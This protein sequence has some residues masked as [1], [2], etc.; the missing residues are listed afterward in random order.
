[1]FTTYFLIAL[2]ASIGWLIKDKIHQGNDFDIRGTWK[3]YVGCLIGGLLYG[4]LSGWH[5]F[6][7]VAL[8]GV[9][10]LIGNS[11]S[12]VL[13]FLNWVWAKLHGK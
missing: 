6:H 5:F 4:L 8:I 13:T 11:F 12:D 2:A 1:M 9:I 7:S 3:K 10:A